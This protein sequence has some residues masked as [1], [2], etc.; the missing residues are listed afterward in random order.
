MQGI[1]SLGVVIHFLCIAIFIA[2][3]SIRLTGKHIL[4]LMLYLT[5]FHLMLTGLI[6][7]NPHWIDPSSNTMHHGVRTPL[8]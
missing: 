6:C 7:Y 2:V 3:R 5:V 1:I 8:F 4:W